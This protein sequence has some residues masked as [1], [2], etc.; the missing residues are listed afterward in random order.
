V[1]TLCDAHPHENAITCAAIGKGISTFTNQHGMVGDLFAPVMSDRIF[2]WGDVSKNELI[3]IGVDQA[4]VIVTGKVEL[5]PAP[6]TESIRQPRNTSALCRRHGFDPSRITIAYFAT[7]W[8]DDEN[9]ELLKVFCSIFFLPVNVLVRPRPGATRR[10]IDEY[11]ERVVRFSHEAVAKIVVS[12]KDE[13]REVFQGIDVV[14]TCHSGCIVEAMPYS[15]AGVVL[16]L[17]QYMNLS[18]SLPHYLD[19]VVCHDTAA[20]LF[21]IRNM[22]GNDDYLAKLKQKAFVSHTKYFSNQNG[23]PASKIIAKFIQN[24]CL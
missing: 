19:A 16:D 18:A 15:V 4:K 7:N 3:E 24:E 2:V 11:R 9:I 17:F 20:L 21:N 13:L 6:K 8:G 23:N 12:N 1:V 14:V 22:V 5:V 10:E